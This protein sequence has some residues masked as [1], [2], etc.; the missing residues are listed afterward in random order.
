[1]GSYI[2]DDPHKAPDKMNEK[3]TPSAAAT[4]IAPNVDKIKAAG[5]PAVQALKT[6]TADQAAT[7]VTPAP[8][9]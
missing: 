7:I 9:S 4:A 1:M 6:D 5:T 3:T 8:K 2:F